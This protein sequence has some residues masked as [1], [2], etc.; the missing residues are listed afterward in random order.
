MA[1][2]ALVCIQIATSVGGAFISVC[3]FMS[4]WW[5]PTH[6]LVDLLVCTALSVRRRCVK[7]FVPTRFLVYPGTCTTAAPRPGAFAPPRLLRALFA[8][9]QHFFTHANEY[10]QA[11]HTRTNQ[12]GNVLFNYRETDKQ[13]F[14]PGNRLTVSR[15][16]KCGGHF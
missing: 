13:I 14:S 9:P 7:C 1:I 16:L 15:Q 4:A 8:L 11:L 12:K 3:K 2:E 6:E 10:P 5:R